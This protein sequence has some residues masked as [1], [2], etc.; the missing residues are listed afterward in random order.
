MKK[1]NKN[2]KFLVHVHVY[3]HD[4]VDY[5]IEKLSNISN[6]DWDLYV[7]LNEENQETTQKFL[8]LNPNTKFVKAENKGYDVW[9]FIQTIRSLN[10]DD[11]DYILKIHT[12]APRN[13]SWGCHGLKYDTK[14]FR[15]N[16]WRD[17]I[18]DAI[19]GSKELFQANIK[20]LQS[21]KS[22]GMITSR[23]FFIPI[24]DED[25]ETDSQYKLYERLN[26]KKE[27]RFVSA[28]TM[29]IIKADVVK[30]LANSD[31]KAEDFDN[32]SSSRNKKSLF[33][34]INPS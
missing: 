30:K 11:Y 18:I 9:P 27:F 14:H 2:L 16:F 13:K 26:I 33:N 32:K 24:I 6:C 1:L 7:T 21:D 29:F 22:I 8:Q 10:L 31:I 20:K 34:I 5:M 23:G 12:K 28:G 17:R 19:V 4:Q 15:G 25:F 3:Y